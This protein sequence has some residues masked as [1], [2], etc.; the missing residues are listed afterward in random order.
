MPDNTEVKTG[1]ASRL[2]T[3]GLGGLLF[4]VVS[5][6]MI[7][8][9]PFSATIEWGVL[10]HTVVGLLVVVPLTWYLIAHWQD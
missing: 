7:T 1:W 5:G 10:L 9:A 6:L 4:L 2:T 8:L 3:L